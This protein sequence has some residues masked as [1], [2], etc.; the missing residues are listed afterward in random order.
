LMSY[1]SLAKPFF[2]IEY[3]HRDSHMMGDPIHLSSVR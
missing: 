2:R 1:N 3:I